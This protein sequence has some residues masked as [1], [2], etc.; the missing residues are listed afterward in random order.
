MAT[1][2]SNVGGSGDRTSIIAVTLTAGLQNATSVGPTSALVNGGFA[3]NDTDSIYF[4]NAVAAAGLVIKFDFGAGAGLTKLIDEAKWYQ[5][6]SASHGAWK[7]QGSNNDSSYTDIGVSFTLGGSTTQT[8]TQLNGNVTP[9]RYYQL[10]GV[11]GSASSA[12]WLEEIEFK[13]D[14][15][16][17]IY[18]MPAAVGAY[19]LTGI[20]ATT[21]AVRTLAL[22]VGAFTL[23]GIDAIPKIGKG[24]AALAGAY[25]LRGYAAFFNFGIT[26]ATM[27][28]KH[29]F[30]RFVLQKLRATDPALDD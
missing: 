23:T 4:T 19:V 29:R 5:S 1:S 15:G 7:W 20:D 16:F 26:A 18:T 22:A 25:Y 14:V 3:Q 13:I 21:N 27:K 30:K 11:S 6:T 24:I 12:P 2:Y 8:Q 17:A 9:Y 10:L 28:Q